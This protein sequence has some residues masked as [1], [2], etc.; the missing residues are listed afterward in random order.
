MRLAG[1]MLP[2]NGSRV[3]DAVDQARGGGVENLHA[4]REQLGEVAGPHRR[5]RHR[6]RHR[7]HRIVLQLFVREHEERA[8]PEDR[9]GQRRAAAV[10]VAGLF[11]GPLRLDANRLAERESSRLLKVAAPCHWLVPL[12]SA[13]LTLPAP[14][15]P[16]CAS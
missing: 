4:D 12:L 8:V 2:G 7:F 9:P 14:V 16:I 3:D 15:W 13:R 11:A 6:M 10:V 1:M 5:G